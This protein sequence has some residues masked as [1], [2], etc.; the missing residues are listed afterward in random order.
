MTIEW[1]ESNP[2]QLIRR[3][4]LA[5]LGK[6]IPENDTWK[7]SLA[8]CKKMVLARDSTIEWASL[9]IDDDIRGDV[10][11]HL[12]R[13]T[14]YHP[15]HICESWRSDWTNKPRPT[16]DT[17]RIYLGKWNIKAL[18]AM[19]RERLCYKAMRETVN[20][21]E[22]IK[23]YLL[24]SSD[25]LMQ[26]VGWSLVPDCIF[27]SGC[28]KGNRSCNWFNNGFDADGWSSV[29]ERYDIYNKWFIEHRK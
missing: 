22:E 28:N 25:I 4:N 8:W 18:Q 10:S 14:A 5:S 2:C 26:A 12:V 1:A 13:H 21:V 24:N 7:P 11:S 20:E 9:I 27:E 6:R 29:E 3:A 17:L 15:R 23:L 16:P 19:M